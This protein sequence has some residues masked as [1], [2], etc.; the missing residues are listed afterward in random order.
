L[1]ELRALYGEAVWRASA[2]KN[3]STN[4]DCTSV[5]FPDRLMTQYER[6]NNRPGFQ[7]R[8]SYLVAPQKLDVMW[9]EP[10][11]LRKLP[12]LPAFVKRLD[13]FRARCEPESYVPTPYNLT[14]ICASG[15]RCDFRASPAGES[16]EQLSEDCG[17]RLLD[18]EMAEKRFQKEAASASPACS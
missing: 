3:C 7:R 6:A 1:N 11:A 10:V 8:N 16:S 5:K 4:A 14:L 18:R 17:P 13:A 12:E 9:H 15:G 2:D